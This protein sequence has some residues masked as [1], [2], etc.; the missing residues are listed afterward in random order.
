MELMRA[1]RYRLTAV[2]AVAAALTYSSWLLGPVLNPELPAAHAFASELAAGGQPFSWVFR[3]A[4]LA[5][6]ILVLVVVVVNWR[7]FRSRREALSGWPRF[8]P[9]VILGS[10]V[11][12]VVAT[13][14]D[15][16]FPMP[17]AEALVGPVVA[18]S[19]QCRTP[20]M[21]IHEFASVTVSLSTISACVLTVFM[22]V[23]WCRDH[24]VLPRVLVVLTGLCAVIHVFTSVYTGAAAVWFADAGLGVTQRLSIASL[25]CWWLC[26][27]FLLS[28][29]R[30]QRS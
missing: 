14:L 23:F 10:A 24:C 30:L 6:A 22:L 20:A 9:I 19:P 17:C 18:A 2:V 4:D 25:C 21:L 29:P 3:L 1:F 12:F 7:S 8:V 27:V 11:A 28:L 26:F 5:T 15:A 13:A 16:A